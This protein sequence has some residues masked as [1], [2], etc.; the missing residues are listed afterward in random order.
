MNHFNEIKEVQKRID[1]ARKELRTT[2]MTDEE[3]E[4]F[5]RFETEGYTMPVVASDNT[6]RTRFMQVQ[7]ALEK[8]R[9]KTTKSEK[10]KKKTFLTL[11][12][13]SQGCC[14]CGYN[15]DPLG[16]D[17]DHKDRED[18]TYSIGDLPKKSWKVIFEELS[19]CQVLCAICHRF[20]TESERLSLLINNQ[21]T[22]CEQK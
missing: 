18:K 1:K 5:L 2:D 20:K 4:S 9:V 11:F 12:K 10:E 16:L 19:K 15:D 3:A 21:P 14:V 13:R 7:E 8:R 22:T 17:L 6:N